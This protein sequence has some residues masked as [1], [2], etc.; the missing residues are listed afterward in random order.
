MK[1]TLIY[2]TTALA[3]SSSCKDVYRSPM[4]TD[5]FKGV[6]N[7]ETPIVV[8]KTDKAEQAKLSD[9]QEIIESIVNKI[10]I[11]EFLTQ[12]L[13]KSSD[14]SLIIKI[15]TENIPYNATSA[16]FCVRSCF[17]FEDRPYVRVYQITPKN[18]TGLIPFLTIF[19]DGVDNEIDEMFLGYIESSRLNYDGN[20]FRQ[21]SNNNLLFDKNSVDNT[22]EVLANSAINSVNN[23]DVYFADSLLN[24]LTN[25]LKKDQ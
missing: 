15:W 1:K 23:N 2:L 14:E 25:W 10:S 24:I 3:F 11:S 8:K 19:D 22:I 9:S 17:K 18:R 6:Q 21:V 5:Q 7:S 12:N 13:E 16:Y 20:D 4:F